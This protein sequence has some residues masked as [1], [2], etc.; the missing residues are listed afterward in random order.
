[1]IIWY[2]SYFQEGSCD[3]L[4]LNTNHTL[5]EDMSGGTYTGKMN[6][7]VPSGGS[8]YEITVKNDTKLT[9]IQVLT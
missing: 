8:Y 5:Y 3:A 1:M 2:S 9:S 6:I 7:E 4:I